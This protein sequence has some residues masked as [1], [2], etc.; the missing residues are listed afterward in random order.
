MAKNLKFQRLRKALMTAGLQGGDVA[1]LLGLKPPDVSKR[2]SGS[3][4]WT[5][6]ERDT[7]QAALAWKGHGLFKP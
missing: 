5:Q 6:A 7:L 2:L 3:V 4:K 1:T